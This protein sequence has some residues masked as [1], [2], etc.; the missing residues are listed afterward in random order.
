[1]AIRPTEATSSKQAATHGSTESSGTT[2]ELKSPPEE[3][4]DMGFKYEFKPSARL[5]RKELER[6]FEY[7]QVQQAPVGEIVTE[8]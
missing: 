8:K 5:H 7:F 1:M 6:L 3:G 4:R 2:T